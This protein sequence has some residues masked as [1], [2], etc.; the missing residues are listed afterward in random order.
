MT[1]NEYDWQL[2]NK[3]FLLRRVASLLSCTR[4]RFTTTTTN[5]TVTL[6]QDSNQ[7]DDGLTLC[8]RV[9]LDSVAHQ[10]V[11]AGHPR[12]TG[13][14][15]GRSWVAH[16][17]HHETATDK[18]QH[19]K[20]KPQDKRAFR[21][22]VLTDTCTLTWWRSRFVETADSRTC[23]L[24]IEVETSRFVGEIAQRNGTDHPGEDQPGDRTHPAERDQ[25][26]Q[27]SPESLHGQSC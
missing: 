12:Y 3:R 4:T 16:N 5:T 20:D 21:R 17:N 25:A 24:R 15:K 2:L 9:I 11:Q 7:H 6:H 26:H 19:G 10:W 1:E 23:R 13:A 27:D 18:R 8:H 22:Q 14:R